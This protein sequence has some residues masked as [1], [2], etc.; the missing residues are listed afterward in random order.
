MNAIELSGWKGGVRVPFPVDEDEYLEEL[1]RH[2]ATSRVKTTE[3][4]TVTSTEGSY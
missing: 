3:S 4:N 2:R 1:N